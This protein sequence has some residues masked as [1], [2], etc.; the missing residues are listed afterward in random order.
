[1][2]SKLKAF[3]ADELDEWVQKLTPRR[4]QGL[5]L[6]LRDHVRRKAERYARFRCILEADLRDSDFEFFLLDEGI[7]ENELDYVY[8]QLIRALHVA[9][10]AETEEAKRKF[11]G[12]QSQYLE[13]KKQLTRSD[14]AFATGALR[15]A[16]H[17]GDSAPSPM[18]RAGC[19]DFNAIRP[20][21]EEEIRRRMGRRHPRSETSE[22]RAAAE[23][24]YRLRWLSEVRW[25]SEASDLE[26]LPYPRDRRMAIQE[27]VAE[28]IERA[29]RDN[30][31]QVRRSR[32]QDK[33]RLD[34]MEI[35]ELLAMIE[36]GEKSVKASEQIINRLRRRLQQRQQQTR[37]PSTTTRASR[38]W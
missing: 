16:R 23:R 13:L 28:E 31:Q 12:L 9:G 32:L 6:G 29:V 7:D 38:Q 8:D 22:E 26:D 21:V 2:I 20:V 14:P 5:L 37:E 4:A 15:P 25:M 30:D 11:R 27:R 3:T 18:M 35:E 24:Y 10:N 1:M 17:G 19:W 33:K 34:I 36:R